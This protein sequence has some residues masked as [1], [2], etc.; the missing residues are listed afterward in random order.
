MRFEL[1]VSL[2]AIC[3]VAFVLPVW[4]H[5]SHGNYVDTFTD[6]EGVV[7]EVHLVVPHS[8]VLGSGSHRPH[9][10]R[11][12]WS[13]ARL[14]QTRRHGQSAVPSSQGRLQ[15]L[16]PRVSESQ[17]RNRERLGRQ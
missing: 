8:W 10:A 14:P 12:D 1:G 3:A 5:H 6:L 16:S 13:H 9:W 4:S 7:K 17:G 15:R 11:K 2:A